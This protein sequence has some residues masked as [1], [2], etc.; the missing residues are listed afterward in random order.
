MKHHLLKGEAMKNRPETDL[1]TAENIG[2]VHF[3]HNKYV[4]PVLPRALRGSM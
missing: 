4:N 1:E 2:S 3:L